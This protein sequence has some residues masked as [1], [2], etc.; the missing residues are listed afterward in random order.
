MEQKLNAAAI[1]IIGKEERPQ[2]TSWFVKNV[3]LI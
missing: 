1:K 2:I 3:N